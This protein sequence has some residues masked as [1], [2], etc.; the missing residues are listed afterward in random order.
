MGSAHFFLIKDLS[1]FLLQ[2]EA[3]HYGRNTA[4][5]EADGWV[6]YSK[7]ESNAL[8]KHYSY[9]SHRLRQFPVTIRVTYELVEKGAPLKRLAASLKSL[10]AR[11]RKS[12]PGWKTKRDPG[13]KTRRRHWRAIQRFLRKHAALIA[14]FK[15]QSDDQYRFH[16]EGTDDLCRIY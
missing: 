10:N 3:R 1:V 15:Y 11:Y 13:E 16:A 8:I 5:R 2:L 9:S 12:L 14:S 4:H 6:V 7:T